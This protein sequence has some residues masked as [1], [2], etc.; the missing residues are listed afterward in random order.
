MGEVGAGI[1]LAGVAVA[2]LVD[3]ARVLEVAR[4]VEV[5]PALGHQRVAEAAG[6]GGVDAVEHVHPER[7]RRHQILGVA[8]PHQIAW[9]IFG[10]EV[11]GEV[12]GRDHGLFGFPHREPADRVA[13]EI[14]LDR[15]QRALF[16]DRQ[17][18]SSLRDAKERLVLAFFRPQRAF[19]PAQ[20]TRGRGLEVVRARG[21][22]R[23]FVEGHDDVGAEKLLHLDALFRGESD[24]GSVEVVAKRDPRFADLPPVTEAHHLKTPGVGEPGAVPGGKAVQP[25]EPFHQLGAGAQQEVVGV[26]EENLAADGF[27]VANRD[28]LHRGLGAHRHEERGLHAAVGCFKDAG[29]GLACLSDAGEGEHEC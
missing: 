18:G 28:P 6:P 10:E 24:Q 25:S 14:E 5:E 27:Q 15:L 16:P 11:G 8:D 4:S 20:G 23:A 13:G 26:G 17:V 9:P 19:Q 12:D 7:D 3:G 1:G 22:R 2:G 21:I 29:A